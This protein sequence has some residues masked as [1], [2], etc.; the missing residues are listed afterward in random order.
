MGKQLKVRWG[1]K[2]EGKP[3]RRRQAEEPGPLRE[4]EVAG[5]GTPIYS[6]CPWCGAIMR[7]YEPADTEAWACPYCGGL[8]LP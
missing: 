3:A 2:V 7:L 4:S 5:Q 8:L 1:R 6:A